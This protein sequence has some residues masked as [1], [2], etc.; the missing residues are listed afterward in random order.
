[1]QEFNLCSEPEERKIII[2]KLQRMLSSCQINLLL[3]SAFSLPQL[4]V[5]GSIEKDLTEA[6][7]NNDKEQ[8]YKV[9]KE[10]FE[11]SVQPIKVTDVDSPEFENKTKLLRILFD[12]IDLRESSIIHKGINVFTTNYDNFIELSIEKNNIDYFDGFAGR[13]KP[14]FSTM[15]FGKNIS[16]QSTLTGRL[17][18]KVCVNL[19]KLHGSIF[20]KELDGKIIFDDYQKRFEKIE[21]A[22]GRDEFLENYNQLAIVNPEKEKFNSTVMNSNYYDQIRIFSNEMDRQNNIMLAFGFS[23]ADEHILQVVDRALK[24]N[25]TFILLLFPYSNK[26]LDNFRKH[27]SFC[28]NAYCYYEMNKDSNDI[29]NYTIERLNML[30]MEI[31]NGIK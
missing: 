14:E 24:S 16:K 12:I 11:K 15:N 29:E 26:D 13:L 10:F 18:E 2:G 7:N 8:E 9:K 17:T 1:M 31:Y 6:I 5:L 25:P 19:Y 20:W 27:F 21:S 4:K 28:N 3:G 30:L 22:S 23:F